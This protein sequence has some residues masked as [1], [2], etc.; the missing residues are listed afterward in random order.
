MPRRILMLAVLSALPACG[1]AM[2]PMERPSIVKTT[3]IF[4]S[5]SGTREEKVQDVDCFT[6]SG[7]GTPSRGLVP[8]GGK[9]EANQVLRQYEEIEL[10]ELLERLQGPKSNADEKARFSHQAHE[11]PGSRTVTWALLPGVIPCTG[12]SKSTETT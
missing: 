3:V 9:H 12:S 11:R 5:P 7:G 4:L 6:L 8:R 10:L 2:S 1:D